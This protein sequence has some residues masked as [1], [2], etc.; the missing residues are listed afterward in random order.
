[1]RAPWARSNTIIPYNII[2][3]QA[4]GRFT[5]N[6]L[7]RKTSDTKSVLVFIEITLYDKCTR[8]Q[9]STV[10]WVLT[11]RCATLH[12][13][14]VVPVGLRSF[15]VRYRVWR[16]SPIHVGV[17]DLCQCP[18]RENNAFTPLVRG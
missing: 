5:E 8:M 1:M 14:S 9:L 3:C 7:V 6:H 16:P 15:P 4:P 13:L 10:R 2:G 18:S 17:S 12:L 11:G